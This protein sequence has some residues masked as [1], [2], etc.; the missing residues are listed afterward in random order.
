[1]RVCYYGVHVTII[2]Y[3]CMYT[4]MPLN[5]LLVI[6][7]HINIIY[8]RGWCLSDKQLEIYNPM[9]IPCMH[10]ASSS[11]RFL[12]SQWTYLC[13]GVRL[14]L[15]CVARWIH[16]IRVPHQSSTCH[17]ILHAA[18]STMHHL[19]FGVCVAIHRVLKLLLL[20][21]LYLYLQLKEKG[22]KGCGCNRVHL[23]Q[24]ST[25]A[26]SLGIVPLLLLRRACLC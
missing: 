12:W 2:I 3:E 14:H 8:I 10:L 23:S 17:N 4:S 5:W 20:N 7:K 25:M 22:R 21:F 19:I 13:G 18:I 26:Q 1:V 16:T 11:V 9:W 6:L 24:S 15:I